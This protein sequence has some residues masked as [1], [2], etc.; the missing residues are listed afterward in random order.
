M[1]FNFLGRKGGKGTNGVRPIKRESD[2]RR[3]NIVQRLVARRSCGPD[4]APL[5]SDEEVC[6]Q[7]LEAISRLEQLSRGVTPD[8]YGRFWW[9]EGLR[10]SGELSRT[11]LADSEWPWKDGLCVD[12]RQVRQQ[13]IEL[14]QA[15]FCMAEALGEMEGRPFDLIGDTLRKTMEAEYVQ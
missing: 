7:L 14:Q 12:G 11:V 8:L 13:L 10:T 3:A 15:L 2:G 1:K 4:H 6:I 9:A 5:P